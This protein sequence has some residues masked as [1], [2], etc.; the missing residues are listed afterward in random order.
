MATAF[1]GGVAGTRLEMCG[2][3]SGGIMVISG[4]HGRMDVSQDDQL[5]Y[6]LAKQYR[7]A[8]LAEFGHTQCQPIR[9]RFQKPDGSHG[10]DAVVERAAKILLGI[11]EP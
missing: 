2:A 10:C 11:L 4:L 9:E 8:F 1:G 6:D 7:E 3:L 5:A